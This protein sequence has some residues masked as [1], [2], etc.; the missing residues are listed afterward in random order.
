MKHYT[1]NAFLI[2]AFFLVAANLR[3]AIAS[4]S[5]LLETIRYDLGMSSFAVSFL[6]TIPV[7][8]M[9]IFAPFL[10]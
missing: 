5:P 3:P 7:L 8:C 9:G 2:L 10:V 1:K 6:T 4:V